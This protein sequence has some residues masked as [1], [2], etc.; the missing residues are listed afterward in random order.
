MIKEFREFIAKGNVL[1]LAVGII[2]GGAFGKIVTSMVED[3]IMPPIGAVLGKVN[4]A[5]KFVSLDGKEYATLK[6]AKE[7]SAPVIGYG[8]FI[9]NLFQFLI[10]AF[11]VFLIV[12]A[13]NHARARFE[14]N[15]AKDAPPDANTQI[16]A[17][18]EK[19]I[20]LLEKVAAK[21]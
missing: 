1:D 11:A 13:A 21:P 10:V 18:N 4:F 14:S 7:A 16:I 5:D 15:Q 3:I 6:A 17:Q 8:S 2:I 9:T 19:M 12:K 20:A